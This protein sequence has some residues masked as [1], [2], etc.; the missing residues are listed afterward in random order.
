M[1]LTSIFFEPALRTSSSVV[2][3][4]SGIV[5][6]TTGTSSLYGS[7]RLI[8]LGL[9]IVE[10]VM[11][12]RADQHTSVASLVFPTLEVRRRR[13]KDMW[14]KGQ[15]RLDSAFVLLDRGTCPRPPD[16]RRGCP[17]RS[18]S[19]CGGLLPPAALRIATPRAWRSWPQPHRPPPPP[20]RSPIDRHPRHAPRFRVSVNSL[21]SQHCVP[22]PR[23]ELR[24][25]FS[26]KQRASENDFERKRPG[27]RLS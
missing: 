12:L 14:T 1:R 11:A 23:N 22:N 10:P 8:D 13:N 2:V 25:D 27:A 6:R 15:A 4:F 18:S 24:N 7:E 3:P 21:I 19:P 16:R 5:E 20:G 26:A 17:I 9:E